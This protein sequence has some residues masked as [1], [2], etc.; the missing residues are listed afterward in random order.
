MA[1][2][3]AT[4]FQWF[5]WYCAGIVLVGL[6]DACVPIPIAHTHFGMDTPEL[7]ASLP[8]DIRS[9]PGEVLLLTQSSK[10]NAPG[11]LRSS[12]KV[13]LDA[14]FIAG[15]RLV[16]HLKR[17][18]TASDFDI[19]F[20]APTAGMTLGQQT[21]LLDKVCLLTQDGRSIDVTG[22][23]SETRI[24]ES[25]RDAMVSALRQDMQAATHK[26]DGPC[27][28]SGE[29][30]W[31]AA[32]RSRAMDFLARIPGRQLVAESQ[33]RPLD[34]VLVMGAVD[35]VL[36]GA[37]DISTAKGLLL[38]VSFP[39]RGVVVTPVFLAAGDASA[40]AAAISSLSPREFVRSLRALGAGPVAALDGIGS[41]HVCLV[42]QD[43]DLV[44][45]QARS[46]TAWDT[47]QHARATA[48]WRS[49]AISAVSGD[50]RY[51]GEFVCWLQ[52]TGA[53]PADLRSKVAGFLQRIAAEGDGPA[54]K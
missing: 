5:G 10:F 7:E 41:P 54:K 50:G 44:E 42:S 33:V 45:L 21:T 46:A 18:I 38:G 39:V 3:V 49:E 2:P 23:F 40:V 6:L 15:N 27:G 32:V 13:D 19:V 35:K 17:M 43:G 11:V 12:F 4:G 37:T 53:W 25:H 47:A 29:V 51:R 28:I 34:T 52:N 20:I 36:T 14:E 31:S 9:S 30:S 1:L 26:L 24:F 16:G 22:N 8:A 48:K